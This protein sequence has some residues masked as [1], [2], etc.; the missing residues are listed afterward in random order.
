MVMAGLGRLLH[1]K[2]LAGVGARLTHKALT[3]APRL[4]EAIF[5]RQEAALRA[6][7]G[8]FQQGDIDTA[9]R[10]AIPFGTAGERGV[11]PAAGFRLPFNNLLYSLG[12]IL[13][14][15]RGM[16]GLWFGSRDIWGD[17]QR[18]YRNAAEQALARGDYRRAALI[19]GKL[20]RDYRLAANALAQGGLFRDA[21]I[22]YLEKLDDKLAAARMFEET[23]D[24]DRAVQLLRQTGDH[25]LVG[26]VL[27]RAGEHDAARVEYQLAAATLVDSRQDYLAAG[28]LLLTRSREMKLAQEYFEAG[29]ARRPEINDIPCALHLL[30]LYE[31]E[32]SPQAVVR[33]V[34]EAEERLASSEDTE[35]A[36]QFFNKVAALAESPNLASVRA[37]LRDHARLA[38]ASKIRQQIAGGLRSSDLVWKVFGQSG[39]W[40][41]TVVSDAAF[42]MR[43]VLPSPRA[44]QQRVL[45]PII[46][47]IP[48]TQGIVTASG[49]APARGY[50][51][52]GHEDGSLVCFRARR[53]GA[54]RLPSSDSNRVVSLAA[55]PDGQLIVALRGGHHTSH[56]LTSYLL[57][58]K[59]DYR[60]ASKLACELG[61]CWLAPMVAGSKLPLIALAAEQNLRLLRGAN[62]AH[63]GR[64]AFPED[65][66]S[67]CSPFVLTSREGSDRLSMIILL[68]G[69]NALWH[70]D[71]PWPKPRPWNPGSWQRVSLGWTPGIPHENGLRHPIVSWFRQDSRH[72]ELAGV[73][74]NGTIQWSQLQLRP[75]GHRIGFSHAA[76]RAEGYLATAIVRRG[77]IVGVSRS[78][79]DWFRRGSRTTLSPEL[80]LR[81]ALP[82]AIACFPCAWTNEVI[83]VCHDGLVARVPVPL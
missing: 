62:L 49:F 18:E 12:N 38:L 57:T 39:A 2:R 24:I 63:W 71:A 82:H 10:R 3:L 77:L 17:L 34:A 54:I 13:G 33:L 29:W 47:R 55:T 4:S 56:E 70:C 66:G 26:D 21:A 76:I 30:T 75:D 15:H 35:A 42:A 23:G 67:W 20:L 46:S 73:T 1:S 22:V 36:S 40:D 14:R 83:V 52:L 69:Q 25:A 37:D 68:L 50:V 44:S 11:A 8:L 78:H 53:G 51:F 5:G 41:H 27:R 19:Y 9:L 16:M 31:Q 32:P 60:V 45:D 61:N 80:T 43:P 48:L 81:A 65:D 79:L 74:D 59:E 6:L 28:E 7:L 64:L 72:V 58:P